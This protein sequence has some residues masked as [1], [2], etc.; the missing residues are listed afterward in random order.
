MIVSRVSL[1][2]V[3]IQSEGSALH[4]DHDALT[5]RRLSRERADELRLWFDERISGLGANS[6]DLYYR[7]P[8]SPHAS[9]V[10]RVVGQL[11][12]GTRMSATVRTPSGEE[13]GG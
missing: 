5:S 1:N 7:I 6:S 3:T 11:T 13:A 10:F 9:G 12:D 8:L 2:D 4:Y